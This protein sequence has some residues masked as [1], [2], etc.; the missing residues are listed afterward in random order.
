MLMKKIGRTLLL[1]SMVGLVCMGL[2]A[3]TTSK[4]ALAATQ[5]PTSHAVK[6]KPY[7]Q[8]PPG[9]YVQNVQPAGTQS[10][11]VYSIEIDPGTGGSLSETWTAGN[12]YHASVNVDAETVSSAVGFDVTTSQGVTATCTAPTNTTSNAQY[13]EFFSEYNVY[14]YDVYQYQ[15]TDNG[16][17][18]VLVGSGTALSYQNPSCALAS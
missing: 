13:L 1:L 8:L 6:V 12:S 5:K 2:M 9:Y 10:S 17:E 14:S 4:T 16:I 7:D 11:L 18:Q 3:F 15:Y